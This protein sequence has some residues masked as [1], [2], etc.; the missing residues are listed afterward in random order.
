MDEYQKY[1]VEGRNALDL[2]LNR[3]Y[4]FILSDSFHKAPSIVQEI[5]NKKYSEMVSEFDILNVRIGGFKIETKEK[6]TI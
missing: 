4:S 2:E 5:L 3:L 1:V 6:Q